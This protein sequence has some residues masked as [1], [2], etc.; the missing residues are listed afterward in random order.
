MVVDRTISAPDASKRADPAKRVEVVRTA[1]ARWL[2]AMILLGFGMAHVIGAA[3]LD[4]SRPRAID[5][6]GQWQWGTRF[7]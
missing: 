5:T 7:E 4:A 6:Q 1:G 3:V 2:P